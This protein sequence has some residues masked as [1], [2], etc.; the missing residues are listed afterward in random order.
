MNSFFV[1]HETLCQ[2]SWKREKEK[3]NEGPKK[4]KDETARNKNERMS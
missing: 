1:D 3:R 4:I 2:K